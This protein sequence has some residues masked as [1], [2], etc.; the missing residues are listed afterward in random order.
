LLE[1]KSSA[2]NLARLCFGKKVRKNI[3]AI[4]KQIKIKLVLNEKD[5]YAYHKVAHKKS[6]SIF[7]KAET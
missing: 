3:F 4:F 6:I 2:M 5:T 1:N 7:L